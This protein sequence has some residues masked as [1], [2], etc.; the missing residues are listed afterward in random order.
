MVECALDLLTKGG[1]FEA[2]ELDSKTIVYGYV[3]V[4]VSKIKK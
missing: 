1:P 2:V 3:T 4:I